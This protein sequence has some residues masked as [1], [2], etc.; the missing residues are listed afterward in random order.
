M[1]GAGILAG[2]TPGITGARPWLHFSGLAVGMSASGLG[3]S[4]GFRLLRVNPIT[5]GMGE[6]TTADIAMAVMEIEA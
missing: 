2:F 6:G 5:G 1:A 4:G 3:T